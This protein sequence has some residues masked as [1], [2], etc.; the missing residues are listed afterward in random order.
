MRQVIA[1]EAAVELGKL[2]LDELRFGV[3]DLLSTP[4]HVC[5]SSAALNARL[6]LLVVHNLAVQH[7]SAQQYAV[8]FKHMVAGLTV[9]A[10]AL[11]A[12]IRIDHCSG[13]PIPDSGLSLS[14]AT[15]GGSPS[16]N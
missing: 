12:R 8:Q 9:S 1:G 5:T 16:L 6:Q 10:A 13:Q 14:S 2:C 7:L 11:P 15:A 3:C 4:E